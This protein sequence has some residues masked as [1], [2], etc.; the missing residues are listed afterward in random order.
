MAAP[1]TESRLERV[2]TTPKR[3][4]VE[5]ASRAAEGESIFDLLIADHRQV[6]AVFD[7]LKDVLDQDEPDAGRCRE[8][9]A[10][11]DALLTP[12]ARAEEQVIYP[13]FAELSEDA[14]DPVAE[15]VEEHA[16]VHLLVSQLK[17]RPDVDKEWC[18][19]AK[20]MMDLVEHHVREEEGEQ[21]T[22]ARKGVSKE[23]ALDLGAQFEA[24]KIMI[25]DEQGLPSPDE[26]DLPAPKRRPPAKA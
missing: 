24:A 15:G 7:E 16:L 5:G 6:A 4:P 14:E 3:A 26:L 11:I 21:F 10:T 17:E 20:V 13:A 12:H 23:D 22:A 9:F 8:L 1:T 18:A 2:T 25:A 19:K